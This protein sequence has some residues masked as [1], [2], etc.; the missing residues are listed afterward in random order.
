MHEADCRIIVGG[1]ILLLDEIAE[2]VAHRI[3]EKKH[4]K[5]RKNG[6]ARDDVLRRTLCNAVDT[7]FAD[8]LDEGV[9]RRHHDDEKRN[10]ARHP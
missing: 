10:D 2:R 1:F 3:S 7:L 8:E 9:D 5:N 4:R 6:I